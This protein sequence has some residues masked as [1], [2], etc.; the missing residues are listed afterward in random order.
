MSSRAGSSEGSLPCKR[1]K[2][3]KAA[4]DQG[5]GFLWLTAGCCAVV[6]IVANGL[7]HTNKCPSVLLVARKEP[8]DKVTQREVTHM[9]L[10]GGR[11]R[12]EA[13]QA[14]RFDGVNSPRRVFEGMWDV[15]N[16][17]LQDGPSHP[18]PWEPGTE[19]FLNFFL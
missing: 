4:K 15:T 5:R 9:A 1:G 13:F 8:P 3:N 2:H 14:P 6:I 11:M 10:L 17:A 19:A 16:S 7:Q 18:T 12:E